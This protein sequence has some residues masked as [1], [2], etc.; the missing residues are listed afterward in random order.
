MGTS[1]HMGK[2]I[3]PN[4]CDDNWQDHP[5]SLRNLSRGKWEELSRSRSKKR[6]E[7][8]LR[9]HVESETRVCGHEPPMPWPQNCL[10]SEWPSHS[11]LCK[12]HLGHES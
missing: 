7:Q 3:C 1:L 5:D 10:A 12:A 2:D 8:K 4:H 6:Q 9:S 11:R